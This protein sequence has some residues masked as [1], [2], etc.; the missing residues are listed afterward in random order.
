MIENPY[1]LVSDLSCSEL[2][3]LKEKE[4]YQDKKIK[5]MISDKC[6]RI[7]FKVK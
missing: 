4:H 6:Q 7:C 5:S 3:L 1:Q 2:Y